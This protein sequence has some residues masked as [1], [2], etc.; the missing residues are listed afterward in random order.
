[1]PGLEVRDARAT[2]LPALT[3]LYNH[4]VVTS[5][6]T[7]DVEPLTV[8]ARRRNWFAH[9]APTGPHRL[10]VATGPDGEILGY[11]TSSPF[12]AKAA[13]RTSVETSVYCRPDAVGRGVGRL[14]Y[15]RLFAALRHED[16]HRAY[17]GIALPNEPSRRLH[18]RCGFTEVGTYHE[19]GWKN[20][21]YWDVLWVERS[22]P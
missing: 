4:Y 8:E 12:R 18:A 14:L 1:M 11:V 9:Y 13:Y 7:F 21:R 10:L 19:V 3:D 6:V 17:A 20:G 15:E 22:L 5:A 16:L 2:D